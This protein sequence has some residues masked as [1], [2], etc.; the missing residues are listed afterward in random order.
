MSTVIVRQ[1]TANL[2]THQANTTRNNQLPRTTDGG[3]ALEPFL[4]PSWRLSISARRVLS[5]KLER[6]L[7]SSFA[8]ATNL[9]FKARSI[10]NEIVVSFMARGGY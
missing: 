7:F 8:S 10:L 5:M 4:S 6:L 9:A 3:L 2:H 1:R